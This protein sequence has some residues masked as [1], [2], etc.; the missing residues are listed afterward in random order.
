MSHIIE[1]AK[2]FKLVIAG[3]DWGERKKL[4][5]MVL[6]LGLERNVEFAGRVTEEEKT[7][8]LTLCD[9]FVHP[10]TQDIFSV[11]I[12]EASAAG[13]PV[14]AFDVGGNSEM[15]LDGVTGALVTELNPQSLAD[16]ILMLLRDIEKSQ[17]MGENGREYVLRK[18][19]WEKTVDG[20]ERLYQGCRRAHHTSGCN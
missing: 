14:V 4:Q 5:N 12:L 15:I 19:S 2:D 9:V 13:L 7:E 11:S 1:E 8:L 20:L 18:F 16:E 6:K 3:P 17:E 10:T